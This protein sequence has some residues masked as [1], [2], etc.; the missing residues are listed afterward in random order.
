MNRLLTP[1][2]DV[3][4]SLLLPILL[5][6]TTPAPSQELHWTQRE[7]Y[8]EAALTVTNVGKP[9]FTLV[10]PEQSG[11][12]F[13]NSLS[14]ARSEANQNLM[15]GA[16]VAA[17]DFDG[18]GR[19]DLYF[20]NIEGPNG[21]FRNLGGWRFENVSA[22]AGVECTN[23]VSKGVVFADI[24]GDGLLDLVVNSMGGPNA[25]L[26]NL[27]DGRFTNVTAAAGLVAK[28]G[29]RSLALADID[30]D[31]D[32]DLYLANYGEISILRSG[33]SI[34]V[35][36]VNGVP[37][38]SGRYAKR[39]KI[40]NGSIIEMG[41]PD[42][43]LLNNGHGVFTP[44]SWTEGRFLDESGQPLKSEPYDMGLSVMFRDIDGDGAPDIYVCNDFQS[45]DRIWINDGKGRFRA[46]PDLAVRTLCHFSMGVDFADIDRDGFDDF[47]VGDMLSRSHELR[48]RQ[49]GATNPPPSHI[50]ETHD[51]EQVHRN[52]LNWNRGDGTYAEIANFADVD[53]S[54]WS[55]S[56]AFLDVD[57]DGYEDLLIANGHAYDTLDLDL[58]ER[59]SEAVAQGGMTRIGKTLKSF[60]P[61]ITPNVLFRN[62]GNR[63]FEECG[64]EW[65][66]NSTNISHGIALADFDNDGDLDVAVSCLWQ[67]PLVYRNESA[68]PR[69]AVRLKGLAPNTKGIGAKVVLLGGAVPSQAQEI[70]CGGRYLSADDTMRTFATGLAT[71]GMSIEVQWR[72]GKR[73]VI[74]DVKANHIYE[75]DESG[76][77]P[78]IRPGSLPLPPVFKDVSELL[79]HQSEGTPF[80][81]IER[82]PLLPKTLSKPGPGVAWLDLDGDGR[83]ELILPDSE[84]GR[85]AIF[86]P[87]GARKFT[88]WSE[89]TVAGKMHGDFAGL[90]A[91]A[92][93][94]GKP[95]LLAGLSNYR[96]GGNEPALLLI[97]TRSGGSAHSVSMTPQS[98][99]R[100]TEASVGPVAVADLDG[101]GDLDV[102]VGG[103]VVPGRYPEPASSRIYR[104]DGGGLKLDEVNTAALRNVGLVNG[105]VFSDLDGDGLPELVLA[106]EWGPLTLFRN[107]RGK[108]TR[109]DPPISSRDPRP[110]TLNPPT[111]L[112]QFTG[113]WN[114]VTTGDFDGDGRM[115]LVAGNWGLNSSYHDPANHPIRFYYGDFDGNGSVELLEAE[116]DGDS[117]RFVPRRDLAWLSAG[118]P[119]LRAR[120]PTHKLFSTADVISILEKDSA[121]ARIAQVNALASMVFLN[122]GDRFEAV[123]LPAE[124]QWAPAFSVNVAD[125][126]G[127]GN[128]DVFLSQNFFSMR[129]E[130]PR[131][132]AGRGLWLRG[133]GQGGFR[134][135]PGQE[136]GVKAY[137]E[138][139]GSAVNDFDVDG[140]VDLVVAQNGS[141]TKLFHNETAKSGLRVRLQG[142]PG[143]PLGIGAVLRLAFG[144]KLGPAREVHGGSGY[145]SQD[146]V[147]EV[148]A[149]P[150]SPTSLYIRWP[151]RPAAT[152][153]ISSGSKEITLGFQGII[154]SVR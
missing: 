108:L 72:N 57:L 149:T 69:V 20:A 113:W 8:R 141:A 48:M 123:R 18:D 11:I 89:G 125:L 45:P 143:N 114:S 54:D 96:E 117:N 1:S 28:T 25:C 122:R 70:Q 50:G 112:D 84:G 21:L 104:H 147:V 80:N 59:S 62:H 151:G 152:V 44:V 154:S 16:G 65:G 30:N 35:R 79:A 38:V 127:D 29:G 78:F 118:M 94:A 17:G 26:L 95:A 99:V 109:W 5:L 106:C 13:T 37:T 100:G 82:Q 33:G 101:D 27:G 55:W 2:C 124:A 140:R 71:N 88:R 130:E 136:S 146:S 4:R 120:F 53:A 36:N 49:L 81:D 68:A 98:A 23:Q 73:S 144:G 9:G 138:Q 86:S 46:L 14:Y 76:A 83:D 77:Q 119:W 24:N 135:L 134:A 150:Q 121:K 131:L 60:P 6:A 111:H 137:G 145:W 115:D 129:P 51:R 133:D 74:S 97:E 31:G 148:L 139:R 39:L 7:G 41:E 32:L 34:S 63:R 52:T 102:F 12:W 91:F 153:E 3:A 85:L 15:D 105:A 43:L 19:C 22:K 10:R 40:V 75:V 116:A 87:D 67:P 47:F 64:A 92:S 107:E 58:H 103:R 142:P 66:F 93:S 128:E 132:D 126:D 110:A 56:V 61:L 42:A 90:A